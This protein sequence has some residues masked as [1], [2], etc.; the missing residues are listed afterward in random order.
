VQRTKQEGLNALLTICK[1]FWGKG[2][3]MIVI[4]D[5]GIG[6]TGSIINMIR[7]LGG[8]AII[9]ANS[10][11]ISTADALILPGVGAFDN[12]MEKL[13]ASGL[14]PVIEKR[15]LDD[16]IP[17]LGICLGMQLLF[18]SSDE[19]RFEGL[20]WIRGQVKRFNFSDTNQTG[21]KIPHMGWNE[22]QPVNNHPLFTGLESEARFYFVH[23]YHIECNVDKYSIAK[24]IYG[25]TFTCAV[26]KDN[27]YGV[28]FHPEKSHRFGKIIFKNFLENIC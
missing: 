25:Y 23:S 27:I 5:F 11:D 1:N 21:L 9:S 4:L 16:K 3:Q 12:G 2:Y 10:Q 24:T 20:G 14:L 28:Q 22:I 8:D 13:R 7:L 19:G 6:N 15:I 17:I 26:Q 18:E